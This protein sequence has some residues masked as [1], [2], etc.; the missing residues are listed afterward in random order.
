MGR[1]SRAQLHHETI[2]RMIEA[3]ESYGAIERATGVFKKSIQ[4]HC[5]KHGLRSQHSKGTGYW[6]VVRHYGRNTTLKAIARDSGIDYMTLYHRFNNGDR[7][8]ELVRPTKPAPKPKS[9][10]LGLSQ[11]E[12]Q[13]YVELAAHIGPEAVRRKTGL[14]VGAINAAIRGEW[15]KLD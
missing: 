13:T 10:T 2:V 6:I 14:P 15:E 9:Y 8:D 3:G 7:D 11:H 5:E 1:P 4:L 12:W